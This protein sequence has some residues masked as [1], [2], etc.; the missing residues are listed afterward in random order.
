V[1]LSGRQF[2]RRNDSTFMLDIES[3]LLVDFYLL[4]LKALVDN[5][6]EKLDTSEK[7]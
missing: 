1:L 3:R 5:A 2:L 7:F 6:L 4:R